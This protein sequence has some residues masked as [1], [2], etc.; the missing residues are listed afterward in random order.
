LFLEDQTTHYASFIPTNTSKKSIYMESD[1][2]NKDN[3]DEL[4]L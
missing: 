2:C 4:D 1:D 3:A